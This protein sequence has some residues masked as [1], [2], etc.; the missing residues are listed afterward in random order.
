MEIN[1]ELLKGNT[2][3]II[4]NVL[5]SGDSYG[6]EI[7]RE[8]EQRSKELVKLKEGTI[9]PL[10]RQLELDG[11]VKSYEKKSESGRMRKYYGITASG[12]KCLK[13]KADEWQGMKTVMDSLLALRLQW[14]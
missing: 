6:Y 9:Y 3:T 4:L 7:I 11:F 8:I 14:S 12:R 5:A 2:T 10:L 13:R 1:K